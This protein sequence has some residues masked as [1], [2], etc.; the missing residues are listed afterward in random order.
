MVASATD[1]ENSVIFLLD[2]AAVWMM[3]RRPI[4]VPPR[5]RRGAM[6]RVTV[7]VS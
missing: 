3:H 5:R 2:E 6:L 7:Y 1:N 4:A